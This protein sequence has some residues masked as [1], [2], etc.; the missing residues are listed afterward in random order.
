MTFLSVMHSVNQSLNI[1]PVDP[2]VAVGVVQLGAL[3]RL[4]KLSDRHGRLRGGVNLS[5]LQGRLTLWDGR[6]A[7]QTVKLPQ[8]DD[9]D[10]DDSRCGQSP[11]Q[12]TMADPEANLGRSRTGNPLGRLPRE[13]S[14]RGGSFKQTLPP[15]FTEFP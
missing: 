11:S 12:S 9:G 4:G 14:V 3:R 6:L 7:G 8:A 1:V 13:A 10:P 2:A 15:G 5:E